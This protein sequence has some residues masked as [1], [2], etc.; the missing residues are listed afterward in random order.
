MI[1]P[2]RVYTAAKPEA[3]EVMPGG[4]PAEQKRR[5]QWVCW[6]YALDDK[7]RWTKHPHNPRAGRKASSTDLM[8]W[9]S[10]ETV[11][12]A[13]ESEAEGY[14]GVGF[15]FCSADSY[16]GID[17][18]GCRDPETGEVEAWAAE[19]VALL[20]S[21][22][23]VSVSGKGLHVIVKGKAPAPLKLPYIEMYDMKRFFTTTGV[24]AGMLEAT[25]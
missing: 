15:M 25:S 18:D 6:K 3:L 14:D 21:Y 9:S 23:E 11:F 5:P 10:F 22:T 2:R 16:T 17:L 7:G 12:E 8:T 1:A 19:I 4:I 24:A 20:D 13:Y